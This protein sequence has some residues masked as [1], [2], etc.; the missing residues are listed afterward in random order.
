[1][2]RILLS[3]ALASISLGANANEADPWEGFNRNMFA[4]NDVL[5]RF[6]LKPVAQGY[7]WVTPQPVDEGITNF[8]NNLSELETVTNDLAQLKFAQATNDLGRFAI[9]S[10]VGVGG[11]FDVA[12][13]WDLPRHQE[14][15]GQ[16][17]GFWGVP[18][19]PYLVVPFAGPSTVRDS[20]ASL[21][22]FSAGLYDVGYNPIDMMSWDYEWVEAVRPDFLNTVAFSIPNVKDVTRLNLIQYSLKALDLVDT[23]ADLIAYESFLKGDPY[24]A[25]RDAYLSSRQFAVSDGVVID[26]FVMDEVVEDD[27]FDEIDFDNLDDFD[28]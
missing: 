12:G 27:D 26:D 9:N 28:F 1:M 19:G 11:L 2:S 22:E 3:I 21:I 13:R 5:D 6:L 20:S 8:F 24:T 10:T 17:L 16:T 14:D 15:L 18:A 4:V 25:M 23:R 7:Q